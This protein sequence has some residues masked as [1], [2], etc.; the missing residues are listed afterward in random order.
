MAILPGSYCSLGGKKQHWG[1]VVE[2]L[3]CDDVG[4][5]A[6]LFPVRPDRGRAAEDPHDRV[7]L[8]REPRGVL[9]DRGGRLRVRGA[10]R[11]RSEVRSVGQRRILL[12]ARSRGERRMP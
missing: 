11:L 6:G 4:R 8:G 9:L 3:S 5:A 12:G 7:G 2:R 1:I 10:R